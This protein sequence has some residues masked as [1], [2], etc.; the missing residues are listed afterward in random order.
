[1]RQRVNYLEGT[2]P[3]ALCPGGTMRGGRV[4]VCFRRAGHPG[5]CYDGA[6]GMG[7]TAERPDVLPP[8]PDPVVQGRRDALEAALG[9]SKRGNGWCMT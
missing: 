8:H 6:E 9:N 4:Y 3:H 7:F 1:M 5:Y 2:S